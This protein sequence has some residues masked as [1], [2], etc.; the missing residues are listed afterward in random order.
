MW[1]KVTKG[2]AGPCLKT[3]E[4]LM[5]VSHEQVESYDDNSTRDCKSCQFSLFEFF[6][7][8]ISL[9]SFDEI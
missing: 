2:G 5:H 8:S 7:S 9:K 6:R 4:L 3:L 1:N